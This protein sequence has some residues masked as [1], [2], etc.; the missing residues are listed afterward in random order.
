MELLEANVR[1]VAPKARILHTGARTG[2][3]MDTWLDWLKTERST[4]LAD[5]A[6]QAEARAATLRAAG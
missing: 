5:L 2:A 6:A 1:R 3:G 4:W